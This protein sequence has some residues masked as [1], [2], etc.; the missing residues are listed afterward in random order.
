M[1]SYGSSTARDKLKKI[2]FDGEPP[3]YLCGKDIDYSLPKGFKGSPEMD[4]II[5]VS[6]GGN[7]LDP[8]NLRAVHKLCNQKRGNL[9][10]E[11]AQRIERANNRTS[12]VW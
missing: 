2:V 11:V 10:A 9:P 5:P 12:R 3:C 7:P 1:A 6:R 4:D 8:E